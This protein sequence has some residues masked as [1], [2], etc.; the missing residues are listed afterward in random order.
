MNKY[1]SLFA[2]IALVA[3]L[4][5]C[6]KENKPTYESRKIDFVERNLDGVTVGAELPEDVEAIDLGLSVKWANMNL[7]ATS[8]EGQGSHYAWGEIKPSENASWSSY[9]MSEVQYENFLTMTKYGFGNYGTNISIIDV[10]PGALLHQNDD[11]AYVAWGEGWKMPTKDDVK[12]LVEKCTWEYDSAKKAYV[13]TGINGNSIIIPVPSLKFNGKVYSEGNL[14]KANDTEK[15]WSD[16]EVGY[17]TSSLSEEK[18]IDAQI[19]VVGSENKV[20]KSHLCRSH[21]CVGLQ[22]RPV[23][24]K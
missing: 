10:E 2:S 23:Y 17:W 15:F 5:S 24:T 19:M 1:I 11:A 8:A 16:S 22:I 6:E 21:R 13:V 12:E 9:E 18:C 20:S 14:P 3:T 7:G 4:A